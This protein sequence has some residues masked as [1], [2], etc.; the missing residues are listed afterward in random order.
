MK[1]A[2]C[3]ITDIQD[4]VSSALSEMKKLAIAAQ[5]EGASLICFPECYLQGYTRN[6]AEARNRSL[7]LASVEFKKVLSQLASVDISLIFGMIEVHDNDL[8]NTAVVVQN[9]VLLG[10]YRKAHTNEEI[11]SPGTEFPV[12]EIAGNKVGIN[13]CYDANF[14]EAAQVLKEQGATLICYL[15]NNFLPTE[16]AERWRTRHL[17]N[18]VN[19][20]KQVNTWVLSSDVVGKREGSI[21]YGCSAIVD[22]NGQLIAKI[23]ELETGLLIHDIN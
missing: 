6:E 20:A 7:A 11:F 4:N 23:T 21:A 18:L 15:L 1:V 8:F 3:Q 5:N 13:I 22:Y 10:S 19:R 14:P 17:E 12:F 2:V 16:I 9:G